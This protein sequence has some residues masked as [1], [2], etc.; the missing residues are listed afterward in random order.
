MV[1]SPSHNFVKGCMLQDVNLSKRE[2][3]YWVRQLG[4]ENRSLLAGYFL[5]IVISAAAL[6]LQYEL[7]PF[8]GPRLY[9]LI[10]PAVFVVATIAGFGPAVLCVLLCGIFGEYFLAGPTFGFPN[11]KKEILR[12]SIFFVTTIATIK[13][14]SFRHHRERKLAEY[15]AVL[16]NS[17]EKFRMMADKA[18]VL[19][20][21]SNAQSKYSWFNKG[22]LDFTGK[23]SEDELKQSRMDGIHPEDQ[24]SYLETYSSHFSTRTEFRI[25]YRMK[26]YSGEYRWVTDHGVP[27]FDENGLFQGFVGACVDINESRLAQE[28]LQENEARINSYFDSMP[29][30]VFIADKDGNIIHWNQVWHGYAREAGDVTGWEWKNKSLHHPDDLQKTIETWSESVKTGK[31]YEIEYRLRRYDGEYRWHLGRAVPLRN[32]KGEIVQWF[33][34]NTDIHEHKMAEEK[35]SSLN[36]LIAK[37]K[38]MYEAIFAASP[39]GIALVR[40]REHILEIGNKEYLKLIGKEDII[41]K[42]VLDVLPEVESQP[43]IKYLNDVFE[44][45]IPFEGK[46]AKLY[47]EN[48]NGTREEKYLDF[49]YQRIEESGKPYGIFAQVVDTT[50]KVLARKELEKSEK[51]FR[52][53][54]EAAPGIVWS[55]NPDGKADYF[56]HRWY[57]MTGQIPGQPNNFI[58]IIHPDDIDETLNRWQHCVNTG[59][60]YENKFRLWIESLG[61]HRWFLSRAVPFRNDNGDIIKWY[62]HHT[63]IHELRMTQEAL[64][65]SVRARDEFLSIASHELKT[66]L[67]SLKLQSQV[68]IKSINKNIIPSEEK[69][70]LM[71]SQTDKQIKRLD[72]LIDDMLDVSRIRSGKLAIMRETFDLYELVNEITDRMRAHFPDIYFPDYS[73]DKKLLVHWDK[74]RIEQVIVNLYTNAIRYGKKNPIT[75]RVGHENDNVL[76]RVIDQGIGIEESVQEKIFSRFERAV[77]ANEISGLGLGLFISR[78]IVLAHNG[79]I[80]VESEPGKGSTFI[81]DLPI[82]GK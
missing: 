73:A 68:M 50:D 53:I 21:I 81:V 48:E 6:I 61:E 55:A 45:G 46:E 42:N 25:E 23:S 57:E 28:K 38:K 56:S 1:S 20:W 11:D 34:T 66:P 41:G 31:P 27:R 62:G 26:H 63:D 13:L 17:E 43:F 18:P 51:R 16:E 78:Q 47:L 70:M 9:Y 72:R 3:T 4:L 2:K 12:V 35:L 58:K 71:A 33:G 52:T 49:I 77:N 54:A 7:I 15:L 44:T 5:S 80:R 65:E 40:G 19:I 14:I 8:I 59:E 79:T 75:V 64:Q 60:I 74:M 10:Y 67:T 76:I 69:V 82:E 24:Q 22:W 29:Q 39:A 37:E 30:M 32:E 36:I